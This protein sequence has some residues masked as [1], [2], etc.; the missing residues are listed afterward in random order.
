MQ[1][2]STHTLEGTHSESEVQHAG[3]GVSVCLHAPEA[4]LSVVQTSLSLQ[5]ASL[6]QQPATGTCLH[7]FA[8]QVSVVQGLPSSEQGYSELPDMQH[9]VLV[10]CRQEYDAQVS[11]VHGFESRHSPS[12]PHSHADVSCEHL[13]DVHASTLHVI[14]SSQSLT[15]VQQS[16]SGPGP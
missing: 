5:S 4:H 2:A 10:W 16:G 7:W 13:L 11:T 8:V 3:G 12:E 14:P 15:V 1:A 6:T 9:L